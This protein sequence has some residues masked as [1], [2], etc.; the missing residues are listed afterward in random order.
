VTE[1]S[2][3]PTTSLTNIEHS[4]THCVSLSEDVSDQDREELADTTKSHVLSMMRSKEESSYF[5][6]ALGDVAREHF[7]VAMVI[8]ESISSDKSV[9]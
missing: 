5:V 1:N 2:S 4:G 9:M 7:L 3:Q 6:L 8:C